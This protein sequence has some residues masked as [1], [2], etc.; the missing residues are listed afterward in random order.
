MPLR[1]AL[2]GLPA[3][4]SKAETMRF[5]L[6]MAAREMRASWSRLVFFFLCIAIGVAAMVAL[7]SVIQSV[8]IALMEES[9]TLTA[10]DVLVQTTRPFTENGS[11]VIEEKLEIQA[12]FAK[13]PRNSCPT[14]LNRRCEVSGRSKSYYRKFGISRIALRELALR[15]QLPGVRKSSW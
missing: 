9:K 8:R 4:P 3:F 10:A 14:R 12:Q 1:T 2:S 13:L 15:G 6:R 5:V 11:F 7:R